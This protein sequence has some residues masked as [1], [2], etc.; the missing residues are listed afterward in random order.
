MKSS[1]Q[2]FVLFFLYQST[3]SAQ[4]PLGC[5]ACTDMTTCTACES[6]FTHVAQ[7]T[8]CLKCPPNCEDCDYVS[9]QGFTCNWCAADFELSS[10]GYCFI[11]DPM[12]D[13]CSNTPTNCI[14][15][16]G[17][18]ILQE[19]GLESIC[20]NDPSCAAENCIKCSNVSENVCENCEFGFF[21]FQGNCIGC[22]FPCGECEYEVDEV[23][24]G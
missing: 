21:N 17:S 24:F 12:C 3:F 18:L 4:C 2:L 10:D 23:Y 1:F 20:V 13:T 19:V 7:G 11:C 9:G 8:K 14:S 16:R 5:S 6:G 22:G 15:C